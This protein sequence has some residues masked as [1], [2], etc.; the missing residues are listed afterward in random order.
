M[1]KICK[2]SE[3][4]LVPFLEMLKNLRKISKYW[5]YFQIWVEFSF[6]ETFEK[7]YKNFQK[8]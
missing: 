6:K 3:K 2:F 8:Y 7:F 1:K 5:K 4:Y